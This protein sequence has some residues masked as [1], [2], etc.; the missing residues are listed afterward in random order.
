M[1][2]L[3]GTWAPLG[4]GEREGEAGEGRRK[5]REEGKNHNCCFHQKKLSMTWPVLPEARNSPDE[6][7]RICC[8][9]MTAANVYCGLPPWLSGKES[10]SS[11]RWGF[12][13][14]VRKIPWS[15]KWQP[16][17]VLLPG[18]FHGQRSL[19]GY[20]PWSLSN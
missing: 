1:G 6:V 16:T 4:E 3:E 5:G 9:P 17:P 10:T 13:P 7:S 12:D 2:Y 19:V 14:W 18:E 15:R 11:R 8:P 20:S